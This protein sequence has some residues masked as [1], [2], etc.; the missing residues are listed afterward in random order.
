ML[1]I[2]AIITLIVAFIL[3]K[4]FG[5]RGTWSKFVLKEEQH[6]DTGYVAPKNQN[7]LLG[8][9]GVALTTL[10]PAGVIL[11]GEQRI[12]AVSA[13]GY[14]AAGSAIKVVQVEGAR[15]VVQEC[16]NESKG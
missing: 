5:L 11:I 14:I 2:A 4:Y 3:A 9:T 7:D 15:I 16:K 8:R 6:K 13:G 1:G 10:R 12:D